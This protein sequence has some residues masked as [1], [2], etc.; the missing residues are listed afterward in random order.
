M[1][2][3]ATGWPG[4]PA[5]DRRIDSARAECSGSGQ[6]R[7]SPCS[8]PGWREVAGLAPDERAAGRLARPH[9]WASHRVAD[10]AV[11][12]GRAAGHGDAAMARRVSWASLA[13]DRRVG[14]TLCRDLQTLDA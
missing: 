10:A 9:A 12:E 4:H 6:N 8:V 14:R 1:S 3:E 5:L 2:S 7:G 13:G 11:E